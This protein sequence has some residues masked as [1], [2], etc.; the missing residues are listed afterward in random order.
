MPCWAV[1][2]DPDVQP[3]QRAGEPA[4]RPDENPHY[5]HGMRN[6]GLSQPPRQVGTQRLIERARL[7]ELFG[8]RQ[9]GQMHGTA[10][11]DQDEQRYV[12]VGS[13]LGG[14]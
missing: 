13:G 5:A 2:D 9:H 11:V 10:G 3:A 6:N 14:G 12:G 8:A 4:A 7:G 1:H